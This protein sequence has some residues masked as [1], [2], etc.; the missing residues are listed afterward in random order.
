MLAPSLILRTV[1]RIDAVVDQQKSIR[2]GKPILADLDIPIPIAPEPSDRFRIPPGRINLAALRI[3]DRWQENNECEPY[4]TDP[5]RR[6][7]RII[8]ARA[9]GLQNHGERPIS[10]AA[11]P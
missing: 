10:L 5:Q 4:Q 7:T 1:A 6:G 2:V 11:S 9:P 3:E 8:V